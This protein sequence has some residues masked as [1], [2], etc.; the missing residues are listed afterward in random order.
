MERNDYACFLILMWQVRPATRK[1]LIHFLL[2]TVKYQSRRKSGLPLAPIDQVQKAVY[3]PN[4]KHWKRAEFYDMLDKIINY[5]VKHGYLEI[6]GDYLD[7]TKSGASLT[8]EMKAKA[9]FLPRKVI[10][11]MTTTYKA[12]RSRNWDYFEN[13]LDSL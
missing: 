1:E 11:Y 8:K 2:M 10:N 4:K 3:W 12:N 6:H 13:F 5:C 7:C 9:A